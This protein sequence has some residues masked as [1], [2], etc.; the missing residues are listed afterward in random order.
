MQ[1]PIDHAGDVPR[2]SVL[3]RIVHIGEKVT[4]DDRKIGDVYVAPV[5]SSRRVTLSV[6][7]IG[8]EDIPAGHDFEDILVSPDARRWVPWYCPLTVVPLVVP[9]TAMKMDLEVPLPPLAPGHKE[10]NRCIEVWAKFGGTEFTVRVDVFVD[11]VKVPEFSKQIPI[12]YADDPEPVV[13]RGVACSKPEAGSS[14]ASEY[15]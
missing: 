7:R 10:D 1:P 9:R 6:F 5:A 4:E 11:K 12:V 13:A 15:L 3:Q 8:R 2:V 14:P